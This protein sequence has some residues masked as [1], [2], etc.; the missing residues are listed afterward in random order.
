MK[1]LAK[2]LDAHFAACAVVA[3]AAAA[4]GADAAIVYSGIRNIAIPANIDGV[5][6]NLITGATGTSG[7]SVTGWH[8]NP[9]GATSLGFYMNYPTPDT[10][11]MGTSSSGTAV[12]LTVGSVL[13]YAQSGSA[14]TASSS[15]STSYRW[16]YSNSGVSVGTAAGQWKLNSDNYIGI[17]SK[18]SSNE[19]MM[20]WMRIAVG[21]TI[22]DRTIVDWAYETITS[23][24]APTT[25]STWSL[26]V[27]AVPAPG[28]LALLG[29]AGL[30]GARRRR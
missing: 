24:S 19:F 28:A 7:A 27:G 23:A 20:A 8:I 29:V 10:Y 25:S 30:V 26:Q 9:F 2:R 12:S 5:Y 3:A 22:T 16:S 6:L 17:R 13:R 11:F 1:T 15:M 18:N 4:G 14:T 21:A